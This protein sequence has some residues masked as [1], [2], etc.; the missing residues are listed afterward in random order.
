MR[1]IR[2][3]GST[4]IINENT[5]GIVAKNDDQGQDL[6]AFFKENIDFHIALW[7][8]TIDKIYRKPKS[9]AI[10]KNNEVN[11][12]DLIQLRQK[13]GEACLARFKDYVRNTLKTDLKDRHEKLFQAKIHPYLSD[14]QR[15]DI[16]NNFCDL[17][18]LKGGKE[19]KL[20]P[21]FFG[22][23]EKTR[24]T[25]EAV[26]E[27]IEKHLYEKAFPAFN[28]ENPNMLK[29]YNNGAK[30]RKLSAV[31]KSVYPKDKSRRESKI[32][33]ASVEKD[34]F[35][36]WYKYKRDA[37]IIESIYKDYVQKDD[38]YERYQTLTN[39]E[40]KQYKGAPPSAYGSLEVVMKKLSEHWQKI[41][42]GCNTHEAAKKKDSQ[43]YALHEAIKEYY[44]KLIKRGDSR[45]SNLIKRLP[46]SA[47]DMQE[48]L[49][50][51]KQNKDI[52]FYIRLGKILHYTCGTDWTTELP[53]LENSKYHTAAGQHFIKQSEAFVKVWLTAISSAARTMQNWIDPGKRLREYLKEPEHYDLLM[54]GKKKNFNEKRERSE[55]IKDDVSLTGN[56]IFENVFNFEKLKPQ[57]AF[58]FGKTADKII[59]ERDAKDSITV[60]LKLLSHLRNNAFHFKEFKKFIKALES[61][62]QKNNFI[63]E[64]YESDLRGRAECIQATLQGLKVERYLSAEQTKNILIALAEDQGE[65][66]ITLPKFSR[67]LQRIENVPGLKK[68]CALPDAPSQKEFETHEDL[69]MQ[70]AVMKQLYEK[71]FRAWVE[72]DNNKECWQKAVDKAYKTAEESAKNLNRKTTAEILLS[73]KVEKIVGNVSGLKKL[74]DLFYR[75][76]AETA[77]EAGVQKGYESDGKSARSQAEAIEDFKCD[78]VGQL[79]SDYL[80]KKG[81]DFL[82]DDK[83]F[84]YKE[85]GNFKWENINLKPSKQNP[86][87]QWQA[88]LYFIL[89]LIPVEE[90]N[91]LLHQMRKW[92]VVTEKTERCT[93]ERNLAEK[94][95][96]I[97]TLYAEMHDAK[98]INNENITEFKDFKTC[99]ENE[100]DFNKIFPT[101]NGKRTDELIP[102][103]GLREI[104]RYG[105]MNI[106]FLQN[107]FGKSVTS[108]NV[109]EYFLQKDSIQKAHT[110]KAELHKKWI[111]RKHNPPFTEQDKENY[112]IILQNVQAYDRLSKSVHLIDH[113]NV[114][115]LLM[116]IL[117]RLVGFAHHFERDWYFITLAVCY[118][119]LN[120]NKI[121]LTGKDNLLKECLDKE[122][123]KM[124]QAGRINEVFEKK[125]VHQD[126]EC[127]DEEGFKMLQADRI[128]EVFEKKDVHQDIVNEVQELIPI[129]KDITGIRNDIAH[130]NMLNNS[131]KNDV[132]SATNWIN[133]TRKLMGYDRK[134]KNS[135]AKA[136]KEL[137]ERENLLAEWTCDTHDMQFEGLKSKEIKHLG[138]KLPEDA[139]SKTF[140]NMISKLLGAP[141]EKTTVKAV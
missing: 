40:K 74:S 12:K 123:F 39:N 42:F 55:I 17:K 54:D 85:E 121:Q 139:H 83:K 11:D 43:L 131:R 107:I 6:N 88:N 36:V 126:K 20:Y 2:P 91:Q 4:E 19:G 30:E 141:A 61:N 80:K 18:K 48:K 66:L 51:I 79:F 106:P 31:E 138:G 27:K 46:K 52:N 82:K 45:L 13:L 22:T 77:K 98:F 15:N 96:S 101:V 130:F 95:A 94:F 64:L 114:H 75:L 122:G 118:E 26:A 103:R 90:V 14:E 68:I 58:L 24:P 100:A 62:T 34:D 92:I 132:F 63:T 119:K 59:D 134:M 111:Q 78:I 47:D 5:R 16:I 127:L 69:K 125:D 25:V 135:V 8:S 10:G 70:Y 53:N 65:A 89:H 108:E 49:G 113:K 9:E 84:Q 129:N 23:D 97:M 137:L 67:M 38:E 7:I 133:K 3:Y 140:V 72:N 50:V 21:V 105:D 117:G 124:L 136:I 73:S 33:V 71:P 1:I 87:E 99:F 110:D 81:F 29:V 32:L 44:K 28:K 57:N 76:T 86:S 35:M 102:I 116:Q 41:F 93:T 104:Q 120:D 115:R 109:K 37:D 60:A 56:Y 112:K 128:N